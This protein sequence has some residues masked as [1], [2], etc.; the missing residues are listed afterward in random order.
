MVMDRT[1]TDAKTAAAELEAAVEQMEPLLERMGRLERRMQENKELPKSGDFFSSLPDALWIPIDTVKMVDQSS[2]EAFYRYLHLYPHL[3]T[4]WIK[5][6][7]ESKL[8]HKSATKWTFDQMTNNVA[9][10]KTGASIAR[11]RTSSPSDGKTPQVRNY[12]KE[13]HMGDKYTANNAGIMGPNAT[14]NTVN[15][16]QVWNQLQGSLDVAVL[17]K[18][19][20]RLRTAMTSEATKPEQHM[21]IGAVAA[22]EAA[23]KDRDG[24]KALED[25]QR[26]GG[27][28]LDVATKIGVN[29]V[30][31]ALKGSLRLG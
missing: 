3:E 13:V 10:L 21:A 25:L 22:A 31:S 30:S 2:E 11:A 27:W 26:A 16:H 28:A 23:A 14:G 12:F 29:V 6:T 7:P 15:F 17:E 9:L 8:G 24:P 18:E 20:G 5:W 1:K 19:L 4:R